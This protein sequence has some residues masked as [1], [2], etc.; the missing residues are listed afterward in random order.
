MYHL[1]ILCPHCLSRQFL[2]SSEIVFRQF[3]QRQM[4]LSSAD[5]SKREI[6]PDAGDRLVVEVEVEE[7]RSIGARLAFAR[8]EEEHVG[9]DC[10]CC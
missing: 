1:L 4:R 10:C 3:P 7:E 9:W 5:H 8:V 2:S 6:P